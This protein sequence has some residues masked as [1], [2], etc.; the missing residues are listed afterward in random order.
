MLG[1][2]F[3]H[4]YLSGGLNGNGEPSMTRRDFSRMYQRMNLGVNKNS[5]SKSDFP[6]LLTYPRHACRT[7][8]KIGSDATRCITERTQ[9]A[10]AARDQPHHHKTGQAEVESTSPLALHR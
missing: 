9:S 1:K 8:R 3:T 5:N 2:R 10:G 6:S 4:G 7:N